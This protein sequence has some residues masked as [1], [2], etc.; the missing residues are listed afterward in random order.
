MNIAEIRHRNLL[1]LLAKEEREA[2]FADKVDSSPST[3]SQYKNGKP[4]GGK[5]ARK[6]EYSLGLADGWMD[7]LQGMTS[8]DTKEP[9]EISEY[10]IVPQYSALASLGDGAINSH[11][12]VRGGLAFRREWLSRMG[13][14]HAKTAV[15]YGKG[16]SMSPT[17]E[18]GDAML[19]NMD[20]VIPKGDRIY[21]VM[22]DGE[23]RAKRLLFEVTHWVIRSDNMD[24]TRFPDIRISKETMREVQIGGRVLWRAG[25]L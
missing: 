19:I 24:K 12:E 8:G 5:L 21:L 11:V 23:L 25:V 9:G 17:I 13:I 3:I 18:D 7:S 2:D 16:E 6:I 15:I 22:L 1:A 10:H 4:M 14:L 20:D